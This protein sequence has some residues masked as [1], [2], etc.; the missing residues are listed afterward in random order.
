MFKYIQL[1]D[2]A[3]HA[4]FTLYIVLRISIPCIRVRVLLL[5]TANYKL[6]VQLH[7]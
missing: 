2:Y 6:L 5:A 3:C 4:N 1:Q 7:C